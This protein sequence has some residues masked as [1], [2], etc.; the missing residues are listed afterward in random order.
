MKFKHQKNVY[1][2]ISLS[3]LLARD[4]HQLIIGFHSGMKSTDSSKILNV[5]WMKIE[6]ECEWTVQ[7]I[8][9]KIGDIE[10]EELSHKVSRLL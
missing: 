2:R 3:L 8:L 9:W 7:T 1:V 10:A 6:L 4:G 5:F